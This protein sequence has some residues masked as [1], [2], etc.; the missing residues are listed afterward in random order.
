MDKYAYPKIMHTYLPNGHSRLRNKK[1]RVS[2]WLK[3]IRIYETAA[4]K[5][6]QVLNVFT[7]LTIYTSRMCV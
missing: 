5:A 1:R 4:S 2:R 6:E 7:T 3:I